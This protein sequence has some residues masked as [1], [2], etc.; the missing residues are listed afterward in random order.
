MVTISG[1]ISQSF[2]DRLVQKAEVL[3]DTVAPTPL[4]HARRFVHFLRNVKFCHRPLLYKCNK[5]FLQNVSQLDVDTISIILGFYQSLQFNN[6]EFRLAAKQKLA[7]MVDDCSSPSSF[8]RL[9]AALA[10]MAGPEV[11]EQ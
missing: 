11:R 7:E 9:F 3:L 4:N 1:V 8:T 10:P 6:I 2:R 5:V